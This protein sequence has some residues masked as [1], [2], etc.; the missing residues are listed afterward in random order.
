MF[1]IKDD[2]DQVFL[3]L[4][5]TIKKKSTN[6]IKRVGRLILNEA[7]QITGKK[8]YS[9]PQLRKLGFPYSTRFPKDHLMDDRII[10]LQEGTLNR[11][12][13]WTYRAGNPQ[14]IRVFSNDPKI[15]SVV[16]GTPKMRPRNFF[17]LAYE[18][19]KQKEDVEIRRFFDEVE[20]NVSKDEN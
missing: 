17:Q 15:R 6:L 18:R 13:N 11:S 12:L 20:K 2:G 14:F 10:N 5:K 4:R 7:K 8:F 19:A 9:L 3:E 16:Y 1:S